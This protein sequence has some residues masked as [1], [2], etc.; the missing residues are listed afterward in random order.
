MLTQT[1]LMVV[2]GTRHKRYLDFN[3]KKYLQK[4]TTFKNHSYIYFTKIE[5]DFILL[6]KPMEAK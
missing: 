3:S 2:Q 6:N 1:K 5:N 4:E